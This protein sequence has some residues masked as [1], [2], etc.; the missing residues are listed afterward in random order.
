MNRKIDCPR[1][2]IYF[3]RFI[4]NLKK[5][6]PQWWCIF[7]FCITELASASSYYVSTSGSNSNPGTLN[8]PFRTINFAVSKLTAGD[9]LYVRSG[10]YNE[11][12][13]IPSSIKGTENYPISIKAYLDESPII[14]GTGLDTGTG[15]PL[16]MIW[17]DYIQFIGFE[18]R[19]S[20][21]TGDLGNGGGGIIS[22]GISTLISNCNVH[23]CWSGG[24]GVSGDYSIIEYCTVYNASLCN[25]QV[26]AS[27]W[28]S[29]ISQRNS[30]KYGIIRH[31]VVHDCWGEG[32]SF[33]NASHGTVE[34]NVV[35]NCSSVHIYIS[36]AS[37]CLVQRNLVYRTSDWNYPGTGINFSDETFEIPQSNNICINNIVYGT[38]R[39]FSCGDPRN[40]II[41]NNTFMNSCYV[42]CVQLNTEST[43]TNSYFI[44]NIVIQEDNL[45]DVYNYAHTGDGSGITCSNN[46]FLSPANN[47]DYT[48]TND[49]IGDPLISR[50]GYIEP[51]EL[52]ADYFK[53][54]DG[55]AAIDKGRTS[56]N[57][58]EDFFGNP[59]D[60]RPDIGAIEFYEGN[61]VKLV[62]SVSLT[63]AGGAAT[64]S[65]NKGT[66]QLTASVSPSDATDK[67]V[68]WS[69]V[70]GTG[71]ATISSSG[72]VTAVA[73]GTVTA[74][75]TA[76]DGSGV[77]GSMTITISNQII[78]VTGITVTGSGGLSTITTI[79]GTLQ[80]NAA[81]T[82]SDASNKTVTWS[83]ANGSGQA[84]ISSSGLVTAI[85]SGTVTARATANDGSGV[86]GNMII[87]ISSQNIPVLLN[88][89]VEN[90][91]PSRLIL[92]FS[93]NLANIIPA[94]TAFAVNINSTPGGVNSVSLSGNKVTL[95]LANGVKAGDAITVSYSKPSSNQLQT[96]SG[97]QVQSF[98]GFN[99]KNNLIVPNSSPNVVVNYSPDTFSG[100]VSELNAS[101]SY[102]A[103]KDKLTFNWLI[104][105]NIQ[106]SSASGPVI[107]YLGPVVEEKKQVQFILNVTDGKS[108]KSKIIPVTINPYMPH[109]DVAEVKDIQASSYSELNYPSN[110]IDGNIGTMWA[111]NGDNNWILL[112]LKEPFVVHHVKLAFQPGQTRESY[113]DVLGSEDNIIWEPILVKSNSCAFSGDLQVFDFPESKAVMEYKYIKLVG[114]GNKSDSWNFFSEIRIYGY[115]REKTKSYDLQAVKIFP[116]PASD[117]VTIRITD[118]NLNP[119]FVRIVD[120]S[121]S[122]KFEYRITSEE[123]EFMLP[124]NL[125]NGLYILQ[126]GGNGM[127]LNS[128][129]LI[130]RN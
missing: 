33:F 109:L 39:C 42:G 77:S 49:I 118:M 48:G 119:E 38:R 87:T 26:K 40:T 17:S 60:S 52:T 123:R 90:E 102:D 22:N 1:R 30:P 93:S 34:D 12:V 83:I 9:V 29:G 3:K 55:S 81:I 116:N 105:E 21:I 57:V 115:S 32:I 14:D 23:D 100:F 61:P 98:S 71:Q 10:I 74:R 84:T 54:L 66:L 95:I 128:Q 127:T 20:N 122:V 5:F 25:Y 110:I 62:T 11:L 79:N 73:N 27:L 92:T 80:L 63:G 37:Y 8:S 112:T 64:I 108:T 36:D 94:P 97:D 69:I 124:L 2:T 107:R 72:L 106:V 51:G 50:L 67:T 28:G 129:K 82:P 4:G 117:F 103:D 31:C 58:N 75:A 125:K 99:V 104:P 120:L 85:S 56:T 53:L 13:N 7:F 126:M 96:S 45:Y 114:H 65:S 68:T 76:N 121:G 15:R 44:N 91:A 101:G 70:N 111:V 130:V 78:P 89:S 113:F 16:V 35:Y 59:R 41:A 24:I 46:L 86:Y 18:V 19:N 6:L 88:A 47:K 43:S